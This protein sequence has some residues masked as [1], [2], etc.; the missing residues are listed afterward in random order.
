FDGAVVVRRNPTPGADVDAES[1]WEGPTAATLRSFG[2][3]PATGDL[4]EPP[5]LAAAE[6][7]G[8]AAARAAFGMPEESTLL[9]YD[10]LEGSMGIEDGLRIAQAAGAVIGD[11]VDL[12]WVDP[13]QTRDSLAAADAAVAAVGAPNRAFVRPAAG[14]SLRGAVDWCV[15]GS[16]SPDRQPPPASGPL[17]FAPVA[18][19]LVELTAARASRGAR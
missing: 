6:P 15:R 5:P 3:V 4:C 7:G 18:A 8:V 17:S 1:V 12:V 19:A 11:T 14:P 2:D 13:S 9:L 10:V 16:A